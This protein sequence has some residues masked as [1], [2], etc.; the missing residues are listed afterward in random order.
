VSGA[1]PA[2]ASAMRVAAAQFRLG[3]LRAL[4]YRVQFWTE[5]VLG[6]V[7]SLMGIAPLLVAVQ[8]R[9]EVAGWGVGGLMVLTG[10]FT[11]MSGIYGALVQPALAESMAHI[12]RGSLDYLLLRPVD[13]MISCLTS[14]YSP[15]R[16]LEVLVGIGLVAY[17]VHREGVF[18]WRS[19]AL[20]MSLGILGVIILYAM[21]V[22][23]LAASFRALRL[24]NLTF[25]LEAMLDFGR[26]PLGVFRGLLK[27]FFTFMF[28]LAVLTTFPAEAI[29][30]RLDEGTL[31]LASAVTLAFAVVGR[32]AWIRSIR[33]YTSASS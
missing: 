17:G 16:I 4:Q 10:M 2:A 6:V 3:M 32:F 20:G 15:W 33:N 8:A 28:P 24:E 31:A 21:G 14:M 29:L 23:I 5:G 12:R 26:W 1:A 22:L 11:I 30:G 13:S 25:M 27:A 18:A 19:L 9:G 7:W